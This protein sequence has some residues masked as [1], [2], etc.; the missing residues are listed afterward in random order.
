MGTILMVMMSCQE[1]IRNPHTIAS[2]NVEITV[3][4]EQSNE[5]IKRSPILPMFKDSKLMKMIKALFKP[6]RKNK[7]RPVYV[8]SE[9]E[10]TQ[11]YNTYTFD[12]TLA[13]TTPKYIGTYSYKYTTTASPA[14]TISYYYKHF[15]T[16]SPTSTI[17]Y[18][19]KDVTTASPNN[20]ESASTYSSDSTTNAT[21]ETATTEI[22]STTSTSPATTTITTTATTTT[23]TTTTATT[24][25]TTTTTASTTTATT[26]TTPTTTT[27]TADMMYQQL[28]VTKTLEAVEN[29]SKEQ[30]SQ[31]SD[32]IRSLQME[33]KRLHN[34]RTNAAK[35]GKMITSEDINDLNE[36][37]EELMSEV[38][39]MK[40]FYRRPKVLQKNRLDTNRAI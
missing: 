17:S 11:S 26:T 25:T 15:T 9:P 24:I 36:D 40:V 10:E 33:L 37:V 3:A 2:E 8:Y 16:A 18:Y 19:Y 5:R 27:T 4:Q 20:S 34:S 30:F 7:E 12:T 38:E 21:E 22:A 29:R 35:K 6:R 31:L 13:P 14:P 1:I 28:D 32:E 23:A 39:A